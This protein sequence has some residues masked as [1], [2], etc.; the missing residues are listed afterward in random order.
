MHSIDC[1]NWQTD[2]RHDLYYRHG[3]VHVIRFMRCYGVHLGFHLE[4]PQALK[5]SEMNLPIPA[6]SLDLH[7]L[8]ERVI[9]APLAGLSD[10][11]RRVYIRHVTSFLDWLQASRS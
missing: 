1:K 10:N 11:S 9:A 6:P 5:E 7:A 8:R 4:M 2:D 3:T